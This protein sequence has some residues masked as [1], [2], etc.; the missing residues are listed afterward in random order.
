MKNPMHF[1]I[2]GEIEEIENQKIF[3]LNYGKSNKKS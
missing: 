3:R 2:I 1:E